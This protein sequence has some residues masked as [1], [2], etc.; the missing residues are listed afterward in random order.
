M[1][2]RTAILEKH[3]W[4]RSSLLVL[5]LD[6][7]GRVVEANAY[8][9][10]LLGNDCI[11]R[12]FG[13]LLIDFNSLF[14]LGKFQT[15][16][17]SA[18]LLN[19]STAEG[20][21]ESLK[22]TYYPCNDGGI[23]VGEHDVGELQEL[24][25]T[26][27]TLN[28]EQ[29]ILSRELQKKNVE[30]QKLNDTKNQF[31]GI[32]AHDLRNPISTIITYTDFFL[33]DEE[34]LTPDMTEVLADVRSLADF[35]L[36]LIT[37]LLDISVIEMGKLVLD[38]QLLDIVPFINEVVKLNGLLS[39]KKGIG[40]EQHY[41][42][43]LDSILCDPHKIKQVMNNLISNAFKFS[44]PGTQVKLLVFAEPRELKVEVHDQGPGIPAHEIDKLFKPFGRTSIHSTGG[45]SSTGLGLVISRRIVE[46]HGGRIGVESVVGSG[47]VFW[48]TIP[49]GA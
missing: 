22:V 14:E 38:K 5:N 48:F 4:D 11:G 8:A 20:M 16:N 29:A 10:R 26:M 2:E 40:I 37:Q 25:T 39:Q 7:F 23:V 15:D 17:S 41:R 35:M 30:L 19:F 32:A 9:L 47:S 12:G 46:S 24:R 45:E 21:P 44:L 13:E 34:H 33:E 18:H 3:I 31:L 6:G 28:Q 36:H 1:I 49:F 27:L 42:G 43:N